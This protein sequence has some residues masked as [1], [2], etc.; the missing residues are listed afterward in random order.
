[1]LQYVKVLPHWRGP[2]SQGLVRSFQVSM[3]LT[4]WVMERSGTTHYSLVE[5]GEPE[6]RRDCRHPW[7]SRVASSALA[8]A[9]RPSGSFLPRPSQHHFC[10][11]VLLCFLLIRDC[12][13]EAW[14]LFPSSLSWRPPAPAQPHLPLAGWH[15]SV[16]QP[17]PVLQGASPVSGACLLQRD[18]GFR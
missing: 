2:L 6:A 17:D 9:A 4:F 14:L 10:F 7:D 15:A 18:R 16:E 11:W 3:V 5:K 8:T 1:M 12:L 13:P